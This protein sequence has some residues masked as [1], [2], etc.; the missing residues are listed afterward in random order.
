ML[1]TTLVKKVAHFFILNLI[2]QPSVEL[3]HGC[4]MLRMLRRNLLLAEAR[5]RGYITTGTVKDYYEAGIK[6]HMTE[7][8]IF[9]HR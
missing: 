5:Q 1:Q 7:N 6:G 8:M 4:S 3:M 2:V 9:G